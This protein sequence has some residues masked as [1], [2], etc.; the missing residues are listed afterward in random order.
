MSA[1]HARRTARGRARAARQIALERAHARPLL[2]G[3]DQGDP[4]VV[5]GEHIGAGKRNGRWVQPFIDANREALARLKL[6]WDVSYDGEIVMRLH[7]SS[8][9]GAIPLVS[10]ATRKVAAGMLV[11]PRFRWSGLGDVVARV[12]FAI[13][14]QIGGSTLVPGSA[15]DVPAWLIAGPVLRRIEALL[16]RRCRLFVARDQVRTS[17]RGRIDWAKYLR[18]SL[19]TGRWHH[20]PCTFSEPEDDPTLLANVRWTLNRI[21]ESLASI[22]PSPIGHQKLASIDVLL[23]LAGPGPRIRPEERTSAGH[24]GEVVISAM[25]AMRWISE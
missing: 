19:A 12:G 25:T 9:I 2:R 17:P 24:S 6:T 5:R 7:P 10:P 8:R 14:P 13:E 23:N 3:H 16:Q 21:E 1:T 4:I 11:T 18:G 20:L 22:A 15:R